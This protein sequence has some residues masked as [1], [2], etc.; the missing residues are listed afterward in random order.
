[1]GR[2]PSRSNSKLETDI[3]VHATGIVKRER[4]P[5][6]VGDGVMEGD[7]AGRH[8]SGARIERAPRIER[9]GVGVSHGELD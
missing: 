3:Q 1:M 7:G 9:T 6:D 8:V 2:D 5:G 4:G